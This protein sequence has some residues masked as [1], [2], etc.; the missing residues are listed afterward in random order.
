MDVK[1]WFKAAIGAFVVIFA[2]D[3]VVHQ[4]WLGDFYHAH[5]GWWRP[6]GEMQSMRPFMLLAQ[7]SF[8]ALLALIYTRGYERKKEGMSQGLRFGILMALF[9]AIPQSLMTH[10]IYPY[11]EPL[12]WSWFMGCLLK[13]VLA[14]VTIGAIYKPAK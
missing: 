10:V 14:G 4:I 12:I 8:A 3:Y 13:T 2:A 11:P 5:A 9:V 6:E 7:L 1:R